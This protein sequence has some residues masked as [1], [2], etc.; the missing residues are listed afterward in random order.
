[1]QAKIVLQ[2]LDDGRWGLP[3]GINPTTHILKPAI[4]NLDDQ[5]INEYLT[6]TAARLTNLAVAGTEVAVLDEIPVVVVERYD[7]FRVGQ[8]WRRAHQ[9]DLLQAMGL[10]PERKYESQGGPTVRAVADVIRFATRGDDDVR[11]FVAAMVFHWLTV[12]TDAHAKNYSLLLSQDTARLAP[13]YDLNSFL[14][15]GQ[16][17]PR[18]LSMRIGAEFMV[19]KVAW[20]DWKAL[21]RDAKVDDDWVADEI[22]RQAR[23]LPDAFSDAARRLSTATR[24]TSD[25]PHR[26]AG[27][28]QRWAQSA[29]AQT[30]LGTA[31]G[32]SSGRGR[33]R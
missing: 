28:V 1:M 8:R 29:L 21:A 27:H 32:R 4:A 30:K 16:G 23:I 18:E 20:S 33:K 24:V 9:E 25:L 17:A 2:R 5:H 7:R 26:L 15:Y 11:E 22:R 13:L 31:T 3:E 10:P 6:M 12:S 14:Y 19:D